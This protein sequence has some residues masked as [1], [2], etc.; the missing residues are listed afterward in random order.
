MNLA[1]LLAR[2][3]RGRRERTA[4]AV[5]ATPW[6]T[7][8]ELA[9]RSAV[10]AGAL[11][12]SSGLV[13]GDRVALIQHNGPAFIELLYAIWHAGLVAVP[14]NAKL[15]PREHA[16]I[17]EQSGARL[18]FASEDLA[19]GLAPLLSGLDGLREVIE[20]E[21]PAY[22]KLL[23]GDP[24]EIVE[25]APA[26][27][28]WLFYTS[29]TTG[30]PKGAMLSHRN[31]MTMTLCYFAD[32]DQ[33]AAGDAILHAAPLSHGSGL[34][35]LPH[36]A[37]GACHVIPES[38]GFDPAEIFALLPAHKGVTMFGAPTMVKRLVEN[39]GA[40]AADSTN[41]K[42]VI[43]GGGPM[44]LEDLKQA[45]E[46]FGTVFSQIYGQGESP[47]TITALGK[48]AHGDR[49]HP[50]Y[51]QR[52]ASVG[53]AQS[54]V[55]LRIADDNDRALPAGQTGEVLVRGDSV[56]LG[57]WRDPETS[58]ETLRGG[59]LHSG[60]LGQLDDDGFLTLKDRSKD[61][62]ISG[63]A[64]IY[65]REVEEA[66]LTHE[67]VEECAVVGWPHDDWGEEVVAFVVA[68]P[69]QAATPEAL[70]QVCLDQ[71]A[72]FK[73]PKAYRFVDALPK[74]NYG[75]VLKTELRRRLKNEGAA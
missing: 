51:W 29:G 37:A 41:L 52:L 75:K 5:G 56:M 14:I 35:G 7:Y 1:H 24:V 48:A 13:P 2:A 45:M 74:N 31:L 16:Y 65:P 59:W 64:N 63:G 3:G 53:Q 67:A 38:H 32:V 21:R 50:R 36:V 73:R 20:V 71:L 17:V 39:P 62:I 22:R 8:G 47:M 25:R 46:R 19:A 70:D 4:I 26:D 9:R 33:I 15:H 69:G 12:D 11:S 44:Y 66:L 42:T 57:Y 55:E 18:C 30:R 54:A 61:L 27:L 68:A 43:Y 28:A 49:D 72:R 58:A 10:L 60:D 40:G 6:A 34:Y 23:D